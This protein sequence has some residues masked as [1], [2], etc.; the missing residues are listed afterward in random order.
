M[1]EIEEDFNKMFIKFKYLDHDREGK[2]I[3]HKF[4]Y[5]CKFSSVF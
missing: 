1:S 2:I 4:N 5:K 3:E